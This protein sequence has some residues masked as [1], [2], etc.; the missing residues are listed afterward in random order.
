MFGKGDGRQFE[1]ARFKRQ[2]AAM[3]GGGKLDL[4]QARLIGAE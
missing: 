4:L 1:V 3:Y 2:L